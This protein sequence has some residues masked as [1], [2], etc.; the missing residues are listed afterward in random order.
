MFFVAGLT[1][2][3]KVAFADG[4][5]ENNT[6]NTQS[7]EDTTLSMDMY[8]YF[9]N[10]YDYSPQNYEG[11]CGYVSLIQLLS[12][13][14]TFYNDEII[15]SNYDD[16]FVGTNYNTALSTSPGVKRIDYTG[17]KEDGLSLYQIC[18]KYEDVDLQMRLIN[19]VNAYKKDE[20]G[21]PDDTNYQD[22]MSMSDIGLAIDILNAENE[23]V[24]LVFEY[25]T[26]SEED[27]SIQTKQYIQSY[28]VEKLQAGIP[29][30][31]HVFYYD[32]EGKPCRHSIVAYKYNTDGSITT[33]FGLLRNDTEYTM[34]PFSDTP[35]HKI[36]A[37]GYIDSEEITHTH[38]N[39][40]KIN[41]TGYCVCGQQE[42]TSIYFL[43]KEGEDFSG[44]LSD[45]QPTFHTYK[46]TTTL[47]PATK[48]GYDFMGWYSNASCVGTPIT[49]IS[50]DIYEGLIEVYAK[51]K[52][53]RFNIYFCDD[54][55]GVLTGDKGE[56]QLE[57]HTYGRDTKLETPTR[58]GFLF[59]RW[60]IYENGESRV[61]DKLGATEFL[62][63]I[64][65]YAHWVPESFEVDLTHEVWMID[66]SVDDSTNV[67]QGTGSYCYGGVTI[68]AYTSYVQSSGVFH[69]K[70]SNSQPAQVT[71]GA[72]YDVANIIK[73]E[74]ELNRSANITCNSG[75]L[76]NDEDNKWTWEGVSDEVVFSTGSSVNVE[77]MKVY[78][79]VVT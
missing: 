73:I 59:V 13:Y 23:D 7:E 8:T 54:G 26:F 17:D 64:T 22:G 15:S 61:V 11:S 47:L 63:D 9:K 6:T 35:S 40:Y 45:G 74:F 78:M 77:Y 29:V 19:L 71:N 72:H 49:Q 20:E 57:V 68:T 14:D 1:I 70:M 79:K 69:V 43:D 12:Y 16:G 41:N 28:V 65:V 32:G 76:T 58:D 33:N 21:N 53:L 51:W 42:T 25:E 3:N 34:R 5:E 48:E 46:T 38:S 75:T 2:E 10:L 24:D 18:Q 67:V 62:S 4:I 56:D 39:N 66:P 27:T 31:L 37:V 44:E 60:L 55:G 36:F 50:S 30:I 52:A